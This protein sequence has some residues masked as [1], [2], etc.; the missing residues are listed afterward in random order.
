MKWVNQNNDRT[1]GIIEELNKRLQRALLP[2]TH[3]H[4]LSCTRLGHTHTLES[5]SR[6][7]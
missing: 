3:S 7:L 4:L 5:P 1:I 2:K 6:P